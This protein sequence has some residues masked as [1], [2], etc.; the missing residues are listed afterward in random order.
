MKL[1]TVKEVLSCEWKKTSEVIFSSTFKDADA[2]FY[3][4]IRSKTKLLFSDN[5][6]IEFDWREEIKD[7]LF[8]FFNNDY[9]LRFYPISLDIKPHIIFPKSF[10]VT[11]ENV[12]EL[13]MIEA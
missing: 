13:K 1:L 6:C 11:K 2:Y 4:H 9:H 10:E 12:L 7:R 8:E 5:L 3:N